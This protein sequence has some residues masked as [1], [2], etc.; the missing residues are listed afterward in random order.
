MIEENRQSK[1][2][3]HSN[4]NGNG[5]A[6]PSEN[7]SVQKKYRTFSLHNFRKIPQILECFSENE[8]FD[9]EVVANVLPFKTNNYVVDELINWENVPNDPMF[10][11]TFPQKG[12]LLPH[13]F[14]KMANALK[15][16][17]GK[18]EI[19]KTANEIRLELNP[20]PDGQLNHNVPELDGE[21]LSG[22]QHKY[23]ETIL[24][25]PS[26]GQTCHAYCSFC[27]RWPQFVA[28]DEK[29]FAMKE[30]KLLV[31]YLKAHQEVTDIIFT[32]G[33]PMI[34]KHDILKTYVEPLLKIESLKTIRIGSKALSY[35]PY[36]FTT[37]KDA[38][39]TL[40]LFEKIV[41]SGKNLSFM[42]HFNHP[43]EL[44]TPSIKQAVKN[45]RN[46]GA[47]I[48]TQSPILNQINN[49]AA[50]WA[51]MWRKQVDM[52]MIPYY[53]FVVRDTGAQHYFGISLEDAWNVFRN[54][55]QKV[56]GICRTVRCCCRQLLKTLQ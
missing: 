8:L 4:Q 16:D 28:L 26:Q 7:Q 9:M 46:T 42:A 38:I 24:F 27:F 43:V 6:V 45:I 49:S 44:N 18:N 35:W 23:R 1:Y 50:I 55:Y 39:P 54:A 2:L 20:Q 40:E 41:Q 14:E 36:K 17:L 56:S 51:E 31:N 29:K 33:D 34:M 37:D 3:F 5:H 48:R 19:K 12:M 53:M 30:V 25:F 47:Q 11:L 10:L 21:K 52:S 13:H 32:G 15:S 22:I